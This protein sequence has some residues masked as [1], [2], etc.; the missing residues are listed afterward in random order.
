M[1]FVMHI[2]MNE[3]MYS[4]LSCFSTFTDFQENGPM[5]TIQ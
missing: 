5:F 3:L 1:G 2:D 4:D